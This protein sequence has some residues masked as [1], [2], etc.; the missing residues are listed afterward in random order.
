MCV[1]AGIHIVNY[2]LLIELMLIKLIDQHRVQVGLIQ[3]WI[4]C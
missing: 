1:Y 2:V 3:K 4:A